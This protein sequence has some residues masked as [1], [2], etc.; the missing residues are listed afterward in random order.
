MTHIRIAL[1]IAIIAGLLCLTLQAYSQGDGSENADQAIRS[2]ETAMD[3]QETPSSAGYNANISNMDIPTAST[4]T[5]SLIG[6][7]QMELDNGINIILDI[8]QSGNVVFGNGNVSSDT[9]VQLATASGSI[10][11]NIL[12]LNVVPADGSKL[13]ALSLDLGGQTPSKTY[14]IFSASAPL[15]SGTVK[16]VSYNTYE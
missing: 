6:S 1:A 5:R 16:K 11:G 10:S 7:W 4:S 12:R 9:A 8:S 15:V 3:T 14:N 13:Y 2:I